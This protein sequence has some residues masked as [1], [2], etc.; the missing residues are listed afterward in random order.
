MFTVLKVRDPG[1]PLDPDG[2]YRNPP[3]TVSER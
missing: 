2:W 1:E 3:A